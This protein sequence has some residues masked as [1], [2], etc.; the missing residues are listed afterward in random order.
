[1]ELGRLGNKAMAEWKK[2]GTGLFRFAFIISDGA[3]SLCSL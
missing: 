3:K 2:I 1:M